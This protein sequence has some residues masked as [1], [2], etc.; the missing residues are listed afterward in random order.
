MPHDLV[1]RPAVDSDAEGILQ[2]LKV[3]LGEGSI[4]RNAA[5]WSWKHL[6]NPFGVSPVLIAEA[7]GSLVGL[8]VFMRWT[9][10]R[11]GEDVLAV[12][13]VDTATHPDWQ[14][15]GIFTRL[16]LALVERMKADRVQLIF[17]TPNRYSRPGYLKMGWSSVG[18]ASLWIR[19]VRPLQAPRA[20]ARRDARLSTALSGAYLRWR[21]VDI[22]GFTYHASGSWEPRGEALI[23]FRLKSRGSLRELRLCEVLV[24]PSGD[25]I[26]RAAELIRN[27]IRAVRP[28][29]AVAMASA[30]TVERR[31]L[32]RA[33]FLP[34]PR[35]GPILTVRSLDAMANGYVPDEWEAWRVSIGDLELF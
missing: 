16:T 32:L 13:A 11:G 7:D 30:R 4:P 25:S 17:N 18:K 24:G 26:S 6:R 9:W 33:G 31:V 27:A 3:S 10:K 5:Y 1:I 12:R 8:R 19:P 34:A 15:K 23:I 21:Y 14:G 35:V 2:L 20:M 22:P 29:Y 28:D